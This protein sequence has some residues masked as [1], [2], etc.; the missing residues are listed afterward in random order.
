MYM[1]RMLAALSLMLAGWMGMHLSAHPALAAGLCVGTGP[2]CYATIQAAVGA[3]QDGD[4]IHVGPGTFQGGIAVTRSVSIVGAGAARTIIRGGGPVVTIGQDQAPTEPTVSIIGVTITGGDTTTGTECGPALDLCDPSYFQGQATALG[5]G[6][7]VPPSANLGPGATVTIADSVVTGNSAAPVTTVPSAT[8]L[9][10]GSPC[11]FAEAAGGGI[12]NWGMM[13]LSNTSVTGNQAGGSANSQAAGGGIAGQGA[14]QLTLVDSTVSG[15]HAV[16]SPP[17]GRF[18]YGGGI[19]IDAS[20][21]LSIKNSTV[22]GNDATLSSTYP[23]SVQDSS[24]N[25]GGISGPGSGSVTIDDSRITDNT[26]RVSAP[27]GVP[28]AFDSGLNASGATFIL[29]NS[30]VS[31]NHVDATVSTTDVNGPD[32]NALEFDGP[33]T[34]SNAQVTGNTA[35]V[36]TSTGNAGAVGAIC[37]CDSAAQPAVISN[38]VISGNSMQASSSGGTATVQGG[39]IVNNGLLDLRNDQIS[40]NN[41][42]ANGPTGLAQGGGIYNGPAIFTAA[43]QLSVEN[44]VV[45]HNT[46]S[47]SLGLAVQGGGLY[48]LG[49]P[50]TLSRSVIAGNLP[51][52]CVGC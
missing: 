18:A 21:T 33:A 28:S 1:T 45:F 8:H 37:A 49:F 5:G 3:A 46:V 44:T 42:V 24:A 9:C 16:S 50:V 26:V 48:T 7:L 35:T 12:D 29:R 27:T 23:A 2:G 52:Q 43:I 22:S 17:Y 13:T 38:S 19:L 32:G 36:T 41:G 4:V 20:G 10:L 25:S 40:R 30:S 51:D 6:I 31:D 15:N 39:G 11:R 34:V 47:A 14:S